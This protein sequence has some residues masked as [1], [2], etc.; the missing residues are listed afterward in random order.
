MASSFDIGDVVRIQVVVTTSA[1][2]LVDPTEVSLY[3][4][5]PTG[6]VGTY[7]YSAGQVQR[8]SLGTFYY[9]GTVTASG[10]YNTRWV[11]TGAADF[12]DQSRYFV[13]QTNV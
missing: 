9:N 10:Y 5:P 4:H 11:G 7:T 12:G 6:A 13:R 2:V 1:G 8:Q 3:L